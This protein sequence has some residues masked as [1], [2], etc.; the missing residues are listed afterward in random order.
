MYFQNKNDTD[1]TQTIVNNQ[2]YTPV[3]KT[4][5]YIAINISA[6]DAEALKPFILDAQGSS[7]SQQPGYM[8][9]FAAKNGYL[10]DATGHVDVPVIGKIKIAG[11]NRI[12]A[13]ELIKNSLSLY[14]TDPIIE[15]RILNYKI[16]VLGD[17][18]SPG[19]YNI[20]NERITLPEAIGLA[21][22]LNITGVRKN[23]LVIRDVD[24]IKTETRMD[25]T[26]KDIFNSPVYYLTQND[27]VYVEPNRAKRNSSLVS[28]TSGVFIS[29]ASL[30]ITTITLIT[31]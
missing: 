13:T 21:G 15:I 28:S 1:S 16:T 10:I 25:L 18:R 20:P 3:F 11:L 7:S 31:R 12:E 5:D 14:I 23:V 26:S 19:T 17:V 2:N 24:G 30:I 8:N 4:D 22:D 27:V 6:I 29:V 9:G